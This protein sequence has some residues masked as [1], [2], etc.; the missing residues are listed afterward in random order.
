MAKKQQVKV[1]E[2]VQTYK[3]TPDCIHP[4]YLHCEK[5]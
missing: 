5:V 2:F 4:M 1:I 3:A